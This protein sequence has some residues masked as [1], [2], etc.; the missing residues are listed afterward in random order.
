VTVGTPK[1]VLFLHAATPNGSDLAVRDRL[2]QLGLAVTARGAPGVTTGDATGYDLIV[3]SS[4]VSSGDVGAK[5]KDLAIPYLGW[6]QAVQDDF[7]MTGPTDGTHRGATTGLNTIEIVNATHPMAAGLPAGPV[8]ISQNNT[9]VSWGVVGAE[10]T[11]IARI[12]GTTDHAALYGYDTG[13]KL[14]DGTSTA[15]ARRVHAFMTDGSYA[16]LTADGRKLFDAAVQWALGGT[17]PPPGPRITSSSIAGGQITINWTTPG[18]LEYTD[19]L[20][21]GATWTS[22][23]DSDGSFTGPADQ[24]HRFYRVK[25]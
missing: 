3:A 23:N 9:D 8:R 6:E 10:A 24:A 2:T 7:L 14:I 16:V 18:T 13:T 21:T 17:T 1:K 4:S 25:Q 20:G 11:V 19:N 12:V 15:P 5:F 22:T